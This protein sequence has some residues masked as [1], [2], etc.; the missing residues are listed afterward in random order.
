MRVIAGEFDGVQ[1]AA[2]T[3]TPLSVLDATIA[4]GGEARF[5]VA[6]G[7]TLLIVVLRGNALIGDQVASEGQL[8][9]F[10]RSGG[11][12]SVRAQGGELRL[13]VLSGEPIDEPIAAY[14]PFVMNTNEEIRQAVLDFNEGKFGRIS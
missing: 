10:E 14:G 4:E 13:L 6:D 7:D 5:D 12:A 11:W 3:H 8:V 1:G 2:R 9:G